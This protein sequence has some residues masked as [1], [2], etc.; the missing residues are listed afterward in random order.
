MGSLSNAKRSIIAV[1]RRLYEHGMLAGTDGNISVRLADG[2]VLITASGVAKG[3]LSTDML[4]TVDLHGSAIQKRSGASSELPM[5]LFVYR[6]RPDVNACVHSHPPYATAL[7]VAGLP[8]P[9]NILPEVVLFVGSIPL[10]KYASP[11]TAAVPR[12][13]S[14]LIKR[15]DAFLLRNHGLLTLGRSLEEA[16]WRHEVVEHYA[17]IYWLAHQLGRARRIPVEDFARLKKVRRE[18]KRSR[19]AAL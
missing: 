6:S 8:L 7:A 19:R 4:V 12:V 5:H 1:G 17:N 14:R 18:L 10:T 9:D 13:L 3:Q 11:G 15:H 16:Y 2:E